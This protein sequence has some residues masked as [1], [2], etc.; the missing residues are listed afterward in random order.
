M[1]SSIT[2][3]IAVLNW[4][5]RWKSR[6]TLSIAQWALA[7]RARASPLAALDVDLAGLLRFDLLAEPPQPREEAVDPLHPL[8]GPVAAALGRAHEADVGAGG[9]GPVALDVLAGADRVAPRL[10]HLRP[11]AGDHPLGEEVGERLLHVEVTEVGE[12]LGQEAR[13][14]QVQDRVLDPAD[15]LVDRQPVVGRG[16]APRPPASLRGS[17]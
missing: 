2:A 7:S 8:V 3:A 17:R 5:P 15:V 12:R 1:T 10:R 16:A 9:V 6:V 11:V 4:K 13:I 14:H